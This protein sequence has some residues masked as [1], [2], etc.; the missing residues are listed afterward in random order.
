MARATPAQA[1]SLKTFCLRFAT[2]LRL[3]IENHP[4]SENI[5][6][7]QQRRNQALR[8][9]SQIDAA[10]GIPETDATSKEQIRREAITQAEFLNAALVAL[11]E[12]AEAVI[13]PA[14]ASLLE[15]KVTVQH[16]LDRCGRS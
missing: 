5:A 11:K 9:I 14:N 8:V 10:L 6:R 15:L 7:I 16:C 3:H 2:F 4:G 1:L 12:H 13:D